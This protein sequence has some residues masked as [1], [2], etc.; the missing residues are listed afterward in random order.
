MRPK[1]LLHPF[2]PVSDSDK[3]SQQQGDRPL[4]SPHLLLQEHQNRDELLNNHRQEDVG[5]HQ[6][7]IFPSKDKGKAATIQ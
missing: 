4:P 2:Y 7:K 5:T 3:D 6:T 1:K